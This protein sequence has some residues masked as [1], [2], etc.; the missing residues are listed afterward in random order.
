MVQPTG[1]LYPLASGRKARSLRAIC[2]C[3][4]GAPLNWRPSADAVAGNGAPL[5]WPLSADAVAEEAIVQEP[6]AAYVVD[7]K[8]ERVEGEVTTLSAEQLSAGEVTIAVE[9]SSLNYKDALAATGQ[10]G[11][12]R[13][14]PHVPGID[15][16]GIVMESHAPEVAVG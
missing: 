2:I 16:A 15:A 13:Q 8:A 12:V 10:G 4:E 9:Y 14:Y 11:I 7:K 6:F 5:N 3:R 1:C